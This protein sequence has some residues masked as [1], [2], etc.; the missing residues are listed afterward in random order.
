MSR[1]SQ[2]NKFSELFQFR[3]LSK[4]QK[5]ENL[6]GAGEHLERPNVEQPIFRNFE[7]SNIKIKKDELLNFLSSIFH[8]FFICSNHSNDDFQNKK[9]LEYF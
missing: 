3:K 7:I 4:L 8:N 1:I 5:I 6:E 2:L 9:F